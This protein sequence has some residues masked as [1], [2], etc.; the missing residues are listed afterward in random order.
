MIP[1]VLGAVVVVGAV[2]WLNAIMP[3]G[4]VKP[5]FSVTCNVLPGDT[6]VTVEGGTDAVHF[7]YYTVEDVF[8][9]SPGNVDVRGRTATSPTFDAAAYVIV[10]TFDHQ[11]NL[12]HDDQIHYP[13]T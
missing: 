7:D 1:K 13:C 10:Q 12:I 11:G 6:V 4:A 8:A 2:L 9:G 3:A 5:S